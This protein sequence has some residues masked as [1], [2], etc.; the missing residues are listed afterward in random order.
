M[1]SGGKKSRVRVRIGGLAGCGGE[2]ES[3]KRVCW[4]QKLRDR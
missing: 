2:E 1:R 4:R 3:D